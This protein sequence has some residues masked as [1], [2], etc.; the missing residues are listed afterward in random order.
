[1][2]TYVNSNVAANLSKILRG[3]G[4]EP[5]YASDYDLSG[6]EINGLVFHKLIEET[7]N[8]KECFFPV[9]ED[10]YKKGYVKEW[11]INLIEIANYKATL[12]E[13]IHELVNCFNLITFS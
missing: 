6:G 11:R 9:G 8:T 10:L 4:I 1:M 13:L 12:G 3:S 5:F 2:I 7:G